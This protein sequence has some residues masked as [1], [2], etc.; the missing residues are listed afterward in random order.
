MAGISKPRMLVILSAAIERAEVRG[1]E[2]YVAILTDVELILRGERPFDE[3]FW[4]NIIRES[5]KRAHSGFAAMSPERLR[6]VSAHGRG[7]F[8]RKQNASAAG[9][10]GAL[11]RMRSS[12]PEQRSEWASL[13]AKAVNSKR[14]KAE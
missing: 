1:E 13:G 11:G 7:G 10:K 2:D 4:D 8:M 5:D 3:G 14:S 6:E 12:T 9:K